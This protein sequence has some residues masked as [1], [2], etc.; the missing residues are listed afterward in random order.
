M[1]FA[2][3]EDAARALRPETRVQCGAD[4]TAGWAVRSV[5]QSEMAGFVAQFSK[6]RK[7]ADAVAQ[8]ALRAAAKATAEGPAAKK[9]KKKKKGAD[10]LLEK[11]ESYEVNKRRLEKM[12]TSPVRRWTSGATRAT[13]R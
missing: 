9:K 7:D 10:S 8:P 4:T 11:L 1:T 6:A 5:A 12:A 2:A 13:P 3:E